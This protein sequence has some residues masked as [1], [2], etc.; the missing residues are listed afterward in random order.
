MIRFSHIRYND[1]YAKDFTIAYEERSSY[2][3]ASYAFC[4]KKDN[5]DK[6]IGRNIAE[7]RLKKG[8]AI[9]VFIDEKLNLGQ[10]SDLLARVGRDVETFGF[11]VVK[12]WYGEE[13]YA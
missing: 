9:K 11:D 3:M 5:Y 8:D 1:P 6:R 7:G 4:S 12:N 13:V 10:I 2:I